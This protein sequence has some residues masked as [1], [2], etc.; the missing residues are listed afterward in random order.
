MSHVDPSTTVTRRQL[1][2]FGALGSLSLALPGIAGAQSAGILRRRPRGPAALEPT[3][4]SWQTWL[5]PSV[6]GLLPAAPPRNGSADTRRELN[7][8]VQ[9][10]SQRTDAV[11]AIVQFWDSQGGLTA[12]N[13][14][15]LDTIKVRN[16]DPPKAARALALM[17]TAI[18]DATIAVWYAK[19]RY[20]REA[21]SRLNHRLTSLSEVDV[22]LPAYPSEHAAI[23]AAA[24]TVLNHLYPAGTA[25]FHGRAMTFDAAANEAA[26]SRLWAGA[27]YRSDLDPGYLIGQSA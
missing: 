11:R 24:S 25:V 8:L 26:L 14:A 12:W 3:A 5:V 9:L 21:P 15:L 22:R 10:Q 13:Q 6:S 20:R 2:R 18:A 4:G 7:E 16:T 19:F 1:L 27:N 17:H 23:A